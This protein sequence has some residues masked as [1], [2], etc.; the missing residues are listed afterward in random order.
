[1]RRLTSDQHEAP[2]APCE[3][4]LPRRD[5]AR[6]RYTQ[7]LDFP[8]PVREAT[9]IAQLGCEARKQQTLVPGVLK[10]S[11]IDPGSSACCLQVMATVA[12][13]TAIAG[14][15]NVA[16]ALKD[17]AARIGAA[18]Q[19]AGRAEPV[20]I[21]APSTI[22]TLPHPTLH[23]SSACIDRGSPLPAVQPRLVAVSKTKPVEM[24]QEAY[25]AG[26]RDFGENYVQELTDKAPQLPDD[27]RWHF[28][29]HLQSNKAKSL[30][31]ALYR[32]GF[33]HAHI[34]FTRGQSRGSCGSAYSP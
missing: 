16:A 32:S 20:H 30:L 26:H 12:K 7:P 25:D 27:V 34:Q 24:L 4:T 3:S 23:W 17:V 28:I 21:P 8:R 31:G 19:R 2:S 9:D 33:M 22:S 6:L 29:G 13:M 1:M 11:Y 15:Q 14:E 18:L 10:P 5:A